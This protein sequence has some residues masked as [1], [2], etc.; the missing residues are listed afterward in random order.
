MKS[1]PSTKSKKANTPKRLR[2]H[3]RCMIK[4]MG[5]TTGCR[6]HVILQ[7]H[8][9]GDVYGNRRGNVV[10]TLVGLEQKFGALDGQRLP[11]TREFRV[12][13]FRLGRNVKTRQAAS[14]MRFKVSAKS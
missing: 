9:I 14:Q 3:A 1:L 10:Y 13:A 4:N 11:H 6:P 7:Q 12:N 2:L 5:S 8:F